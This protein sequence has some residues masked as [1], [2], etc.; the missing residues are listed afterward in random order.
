MS[1]SKKKI[2]IIKFAS[3]NLFS[4]QNALSNMGKVKIIT[5]VNKFRNIDI[6]VLPGVGTFSGAM[7]FLRKKKLDKK[8]TEYAK[9][10]KA[11]IGVCLGMQI[12]LEKGFETKKTKGLSLIKGNVIK[13]KKKSPNIGWSKIK[14]FKNKVKK[15]NN[16][17]Y[18]VHSNYCNVDT[19][20]LKAISEFNGQVF[21]AIIQKKNIIG[22]QFH[23]EKSGFEGVKLLKKIVKKL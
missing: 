17:F 16:F 3:T 1:D 11:I 19:S 2:G 15:N 8:I 10:G 7:S 14:F 12:L 22:I 23:P 5:N 20:S 13:F 21:P 9:S 6:L 4:I 18:F